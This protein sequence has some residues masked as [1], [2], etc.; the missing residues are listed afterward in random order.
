MSYVRHALKGRFQNC[1]VEA[2]RQEMTSLLAT[3][4]G[5]AKD[6]YERL[7]IEDLTAQLAASNT[8]P[9]PATPSK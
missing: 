7:L 1:R 4:A 2:S 8:Q 3:A 9:A 6:F 5:E